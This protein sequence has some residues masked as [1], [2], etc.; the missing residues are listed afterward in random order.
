MLKKI[1][2]VIPC[3]N[4]E[5]T[6]AIIYK[7]LVQVDRKLQDFY[8][9]Y[10]FINDGSTDDTLLKLRQLSKKQNVHYLSFSRNFGKEAALYAGLKEANG[11]YVT[12]MDADLQD[13]PELLIKMVRILEQGEYDCVG[14]RRINRRGEPSI[15]S[16]FARKFYQLI[17]RIGEVEMVDGARDFRLMTRQMV[18]SVLELSEY[19]RFSKGLFAWV[20]YNTKYL[21]YE[22]RERVAGQTSWSFWSLFKYSIDGIVNFS[23][24][25]LNL[26]S[27]VGAFSCFASIIAMIFIV[28]K[29]LIFKDPTSGWPSLVCIIL[30]IGGI[31]LLCL[32]IVGKYISKIF[33]E[34]KKR[35]IY[36]IKERDK[37]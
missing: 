34:T 30:F 37:K 9:E 21:E 17:N 35:P 24:A 16:W 33:L 19:N 2:I 8:F 13:P 6:I 31:Q 23:E 15:R 25:P 18:D 29:T 32:G 22:N 28:V 14:T 12:V 10:I 7:E 3:Y 4:E 20:G 27:F 36:I 11:D 5:E 1:S 26:A